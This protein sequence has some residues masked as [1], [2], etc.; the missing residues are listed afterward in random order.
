MA[1]L[2]LDD[3]AAGF[4]APRPIMKQGIA[5]A[6]VGGLRG[7]TPW[8]AAGIPGAE[9]HSDFAA[10]EKGLAAWLKSGAPRQPDAAGQIAERYHPLVIAARH[11][12][13]YREVLQR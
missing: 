13:I 7:Y 3:V 11:L 4:M 9:L 5:M 1:I 2:S 8:Y 12:E 10:L 6:A